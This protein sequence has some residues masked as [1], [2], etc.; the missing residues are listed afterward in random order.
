MAG[1]LVGGAFLSGFVNVVFDRLLSPEVASLIRG[2]KLDHKLVERLKTTLYAVEAVLNDAEHK[3]INDHAVKKWLHDLRDAVYVADDLLDRLSTE[4]ATHK[5]VNAYFSRFLNLGDRKVVS[6]IEVI[7][8]RLEYLVKFKDTL[9]LKEI[10]SENFSW[11]K[12]TSLPEGPGSGSDIYGRDQDKEN[13]KKLLLDVSSEENVCVIPIV[14]MGGVGKTTLV[15]WLYND[16]NLMGKFDLKAWVC[17]SEESDVFNIT[18]AVIAAVTR[19]ACDAKDLNLLQLDLK[20]KLSGK[21]FL[22]VLDD[23]WNIDQHGWNSFKKPF[24][25]GTKGSKILV[26]TRLE[27]VASI[28]QTVPPYPLHELSDEYCWSVFAKHARFPESGGDSNLERIGKDIVKRCRG[29]PLAAET[30]GSLLQ[31][32]HDAGNWKTVLTSDLW[33]IPMEDSKIIPALKI[34]YYHLPPHLKRCFAYFAL[35]PKDYRFYEDELIP[36]WMGEDLLRSPKRG[37]T[38]EKVGYECFADFTSRSFLKKLRTDYGYF[39]MHDLMHDLAISV[40]GE[41]YFWSEELGMFDKSKTLTRHLSYGTLTHSISKTFDAIDELKSLRTFLQ[42]QFSRPSLP[43]ERAILIILSKFK[44]LRV[45]SFNNC[46]EFRVL[47]D[48]IGELIHLRYLDLSDTSIE[49][50]PTSLSKLY[51]LQTLKL[52]SCDCLTMLP[53][54]MQ[55]LVNLRHLDVTGTKLKEMPRGMSKLKHLQYLS[56]FVVG[57]HEENGIKELGELSDLHQFLQLMKL[58]NVTNSSEAEEARIKNKTHIKCLTLDWSRDRDMN[59]SSHIEGEIFDKLQPH[60]GLE[61]LEIVGYRGT[62]FSDWVGHSSYHKMTHVTLASCRNC[63]FLPSLGQLPHLKS[64]LISYFDMLERIG[65]EFYKNGNDVSSLETPFPSLVKLRF[66]GMSCWEVW[67]SSESYAFPQLE[68]LKII[69]CP[70]LRGDLPHQLPLLKRLD[71][72]SCPKLT[73]LPNQFLALEVLRIGECEL[74]VSSLKQTPSLQELRISGSNGVRLQEFPILLQSLFVE[75][76]ELV[77]SVIGVITSAQPTCLQS[78]SIS[79]C[80][81]ALAISSDCLPKCLKNLT[82]ENCRNVHVPNQ[83][84]LLESL[85]IID[86]CDSLASFSLEAFPNL[87][88]LEIRGCLTL[89]S[90]SMPPVQSKASILESLDIYSCPNF[91]GFPTEGLDAPKLTGFYL[92]DC[93]MLKSLPSHMN[94]LLPRLNSLSMRDCPN[95]DSFSEGGLPAN[96]ATLGIVNCEN[97]LMCLSLIGVH[98]GLT[99]LTIG[100][101]NSF[102][103]EGLLPQLPSLATLEL[104]DFETMETMDCNSLLHL[105]SLQVLSIRD[106]PKLNNMVGE[107]LPPSLIKLEI[108]RSPL[109]GKLCKKKHPQ[110]WDRISHISGIKVDWKWVS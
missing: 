66:D 38:L 79:N 80:S 11:R 85:T 71:I 43:F 24:Q 55:N 45:L 28:V 46:R 67:H 109:L 101:A 95:I 54:G 35:F 91:V 88:C 62:R 93:H 37:E 52:S 57:K 89:Q 64:L 59:T 87:M 92:E 53:S 3:Q 40:A 51:N 69:D 14:G 48:Q 83:H 12:T 6:E 16:E 56:D 78:L 30:L 84:S 21:R 33:G 97:L 34:S 58:E 31:T 73:N 61:A 63:C 102:L 32:K 47:P 44:Y 99:N 90:F 15:Q 36:L 17:V 19:D 110:I 104:E 8:S 23:V 75:G 1:A 98:Q 100:G 9:G 39:V 41:F 81:C 82:I 2:K 107:R 108:N 25:Y 70:G 18:K 50:L 77:E 76:L 13:M 74:L 68:A 7:T 42:V 96:L 29:L 65:D 103:R 20:E 86:S 105:T 60:K 94:T 49:T 22:V 10:P 106:C 26:T 27:K 4:A 5:E 72:Q